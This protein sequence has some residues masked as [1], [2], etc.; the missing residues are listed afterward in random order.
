M[1]K[2]IKKAEELLQ[3][4]D[5]IKYNTKGMFHCVQRYFL[6]LLKI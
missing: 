2:K 6:R 4:K 3:K 5:V 1:F